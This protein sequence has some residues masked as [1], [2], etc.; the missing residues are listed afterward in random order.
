MQNCS[1]ILVFNLSDL[2]ANHSEVRR[3]RRIVDALSSFLCKQFGSDHFIFS[4]DRDR[5]DDD[6]TS[7]LNRRD[8]SSNIRRLDRTTLFFSVRD[9]CHQLRSVVNAYNPLLRV[10]NSEHVTD[11]SLCERETTPGIQRQRPMHCLVFSLH[12]QHKLHRFP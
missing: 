6:V 8:A 5:N 2:V 7:D 10:I 3:F 11:L 12:Q 9:V 1:I 4:I